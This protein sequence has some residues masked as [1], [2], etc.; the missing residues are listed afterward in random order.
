MIVMLVI[1][2]LYQLSFFAIYCMSQSV[3][4]IT[5]NAEFLNGK[6]QMHL[7]I[8]QFLEGA[9]SPFTLLYPSSKAQENVGSSSFYS[10][11]SCS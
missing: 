8:D 2:M 10:G 7:Y 5:Y 9:R 4:G 3:L 11:V 6:V 1:S